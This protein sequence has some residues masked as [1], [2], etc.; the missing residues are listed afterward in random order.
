MVDRVL[1]ETSVASLDMDAFANGTDIYPSPSRMGS[2]Q[3]YDPGSQEPPARWRC[4]WRMKGA[5][6]DA[7]GSASSAARAVVGRMLG[8]PLHS[9]GQHHLSLSQVMQVVD[10]LLPRCSSP[11][12]E[13]SGPGWP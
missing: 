11:T 2:H 10:S 7:A 8:W 1:G 5:G 13:E 9:G 4:N 6:V 12:P 3:G